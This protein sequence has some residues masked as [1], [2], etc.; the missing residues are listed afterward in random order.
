MKITYGD[1][2]YAMVTYQYSGSV[3]VNLSSTSKEPT[4]TLEIRQLS[5]KGRV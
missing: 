4:S 5:A 1:E 2:H 3:K